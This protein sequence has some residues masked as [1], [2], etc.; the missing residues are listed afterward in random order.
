MWPVFVTRSFSEISVQLEER[1]DVENVKSFIVRLQVRRK[2]YPLVGY[3]EVIMLF[4]CDSGKV[5]R[6]SSG[7]E[8]D[9]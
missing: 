9:H 7:T 5:Q 6:C 2:K 4:D 3:Y 1:H 8:G